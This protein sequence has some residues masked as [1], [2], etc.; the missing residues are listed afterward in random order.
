M[1]SAV[2]ANQKYTGIRMP[3]NGVDAKKNLATSELANSSL[4]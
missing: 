2:M 1:A 3:E 4:R